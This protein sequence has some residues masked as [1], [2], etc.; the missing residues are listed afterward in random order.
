MIE[1][2]NDKLLN[3]I[4]INNY[5]VVTDFDNTITT[6]KSFTTF[7][8]FGLSGLYPKEYINEI[9]KDYNYYHPLELDLKLSESKRTSI[10]E[11]WMNSSLNLMLKYKVKESDINKILTTK[12][13]LILRKEAIK[14]IKLLNKYNIPLIINSAGIGNFIIELLKI[15]NCYTDNIY[16]YSN[17]LQFNNNEII[18]ELPYYVNS[19][20]KHN[21]KLPEIYKE[22]IDNKKFAIVIG[23]QISDINMASNLPKQDIISFGFLENNVIENKSIFKNNYDVI[24]TDN[25]SF[26]PINKMLK[27]EI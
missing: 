23:D 11:E 10:A 27:L 6:N 24:L 26:K 22:K 15:N 25:E 2:Q 18:K 21:I 7:S 19:M 12:D 14:F 1:Q 5:Y 4:N 8:L 16:V 3:E 17:I 9:K 20:N 13:L